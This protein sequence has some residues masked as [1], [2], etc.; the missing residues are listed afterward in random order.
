MDNSNKQIKFIEGPL[1]RWEEFKYLIDVCYDMFNGIRKLHF[2]GPCVTFFGSARF[3]EQ[4]KYYQITLELASKIAQLGFTVMTGGGPGIMEAANRGAKSVYGKSVGCNIKLPLEQMPNPYLDRWV[5]MDY[6]F[7]RKTLLIKYS[8]AFIVM[9]GGFGTLDE[10]FEA[11]TL[12]QTK[13]LHNFPVIIFGKEYYKKLIEFM[14]DLAR[15]GAIKASDN[16]LIFVTDDIEEAVQWIKTNVEI[17]D[18]LAAYNSPN[19]F[20]WLFEKKL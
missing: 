10:F 3:T 2:V 16:N 1:S 5:T 4:H 7:T 19:A 15:S 9:P 17:K 8:Y 12:I 13:K 14:D 6:F 18:K 20:S 11:L